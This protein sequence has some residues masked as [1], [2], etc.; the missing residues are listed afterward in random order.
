MRLLSGDQVRRLPTVG[1]GL[2]VQ[3]S[4][5]RNFAP[6]PSGRATTSPDFSPT[7]P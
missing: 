5:V 7:L 6:E 2:L 4:S 1:M 3:E